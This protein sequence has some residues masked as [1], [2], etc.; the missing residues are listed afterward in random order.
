MKR[1]QENLLINYLLTLCLVTLMIL[2]QASQVMASDEVTVK[3]TT[4]EELCNAIENASD[5]DVIGISNVINIGSSVIIGK[6]NKH[7][8]LQRTNPQA[9]II[10][11]GW[12]GNYSTITNVTFDGNGITSEYPFLRINHYVTVE[13]T[14]FRN[15]VSTDSGGAVSVSIGQVYFNNCIFENN[16]ALN[17]GHA[18]INGNSIVY[19]N[20]CTFINGHAEDKGGAIIN[21]VTTST[22][23]ITDSIITENRAENIG[24]GFINYG[25]VDVTGTK[26]YNNT[27]GIG[28]ADV[29]AIGW[30]N[31]YFNDSLEDLKELFA[32]ININPT[33]WVTDYVDET[34]NAY[35]TNYLRLDYEVIPTKIILTPESLGVAGD[36]KITGLESGKYYKITS[37]EVVSYSKADGTLTTNEAEAEA[38]MGTEIIGLLNGETYLVEEYTPP[39]PEPEPEEPEPTSEP[40]EEPEEPI[41]ESEPNDDQNEEPAPDPDPI[42]DDP[43]EAPT[44]TP[45][46]TP[47]PSSNSG[48]NHSHSSNTTKSVSKTE[49]KS[50]ITLSYGKAVLDTTKTEYLLGYADGLL[51]SKGTVTRAELVQIVYRLLTPESKAAIYSNKN[52]FKDVTANDWYNEAVSTL[53]D[54]G[55]ISMSADKK[56]N[57]DK[58]ITWG[59]MVTILA[60]FA[61]PNH[62]WK[63]ITRHWA[64][65][66]LNTAISNRWFE[67]NDQ[68]NPDGEVTR[69]E[70]LNFINTMFDWTTK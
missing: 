19:F 10:I 22:V 41:D 46:P 30:A 51:G 64:R 47:K 1:R 39:T 36:G 16:T 25:I 5:G 17:G 11:G 61:E 50:T 33:G 15:S 52:S 54:A 67:Y 2:C 8:I 49:S 6:T 24:G 45:T 9:G 44:P 48:N 37:G 3:V 65:D 20:N 38:L 69:V 27:A 53:L 40:S 42:N 21:S 23:Y 35:N 59:E 66:A 13:N 56:F 18:A 7:V 34:S 43:D 62:E 26:I 32:S 60:K 70:M 12:E 28:G 14:I 68:F 31:I 63:I 29:A 4:W 58:N 57:P 55:L